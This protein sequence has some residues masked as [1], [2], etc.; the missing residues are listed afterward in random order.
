[1]C[2]RPGPVCVICE[3]R[4]AADIIVGEAA[5]AGL[6]ARCRDG[7]AEAAGHFGGDLTRWL[8]VPVAR[9]PEG[10]LRRAFDCAA[11]SERSGRAS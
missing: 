10:L 7:I 3:A 9:V 6:C 4:E 5:A 8:L 11:P 1:M 2:E